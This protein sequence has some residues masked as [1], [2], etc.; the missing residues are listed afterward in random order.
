[1]KRY[2]TV[3]EVVCEAYDEDEAYNT[4]GEYLRGNCMDDGIMLEC[5]TFELSGN[6][7]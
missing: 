2:R 1:M 4:A 3:I 7:E 6:H 5:R